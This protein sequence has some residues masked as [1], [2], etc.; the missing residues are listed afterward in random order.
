M[1]VMQITGTSE[2][3]RQQHMAAT[4][5]AGQRVAATAANANKGPQTR[6][7][8]PGKCTR[9]RAHERGRANKRG[10]GSRQMRTRAGKCERRRGS[11]GGSSSN[12]GPPSPPFYLF[13][14]SFLVSEPYPPPPFFFLLFFI[15]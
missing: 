12:S 8:R 7:M 3:E 1:Y 14:F 11:N 6:Q 9:T 15:L 13:Y 5:A 4:M 2:N 10:N